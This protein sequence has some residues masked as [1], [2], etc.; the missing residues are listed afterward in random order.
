MPSRPPQIAESALK[1]ELERERQ[2]LAAKTERLRELRLAKETAEKALGPMLAAQR[3]RRFDER[4]HVFLPLR[5]W[6]TCGSFLNVQ[7]VHGFPC[8]YGVGPVS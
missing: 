3:G 8:S 6:R 5:S 1:Q 4:T 2:A 7:E